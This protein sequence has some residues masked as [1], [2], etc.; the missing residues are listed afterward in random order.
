MLVNKG[1]AGNIYKDSKSRFP[2]KCP[3]VRKVKEN[4]YREKKNYLIAENNKKR[5]KRISFLLC[6]LNPPMKMTKE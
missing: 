5:L 1:I 2:R 4:I 3:V 6:I